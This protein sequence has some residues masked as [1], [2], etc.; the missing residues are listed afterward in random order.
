MGG[1]TLGGLHKILV[2][3]VATKTMKD[4]HDNDF[5]EDLFVSASGS[6]FASAR[7]GGGC[8]RI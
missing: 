3:C 6:H 1:H 4:H 8:R 7:D 2:L 5:N